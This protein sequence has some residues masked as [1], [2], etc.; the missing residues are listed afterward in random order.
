LARVADGSV[1]RY[2]DPISRWSAPGRSGYRALV[3]RQVRGLIR[4]GLV[5]EGEARGLVV[6]AAV[7]DAGRAELGRTSE[8]A[9]A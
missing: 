5:V 9:A 7:T 8:P 6:Y 1:Y 4:D 3:T 2:A